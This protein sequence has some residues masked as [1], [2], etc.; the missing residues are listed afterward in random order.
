MTEKEEDG[1]DPNK[2]PLHL[3]HQK[4]KNELK[5]VSEDVIERYFEHIKQEFENKMKE[6]AINDA[7][8][9]KKNKN[10][11]FTQ[12]GSTKTRTKQTQSSSFQAVSRDNIDERAR[13]TRKGYSGNEYNVTDSVISKKPVCLVRI[14]QHLQERRYR[15]EKGGCSK[16]NTS[17]C[18]HSNE[19]VKGQIESLK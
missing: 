6:E 10:F 12:Y 2:V 13:N 1:L 19:R 18:R 7:A 11:N 14:A 9:L 4:L 15:E 3:I 8:Q 17:H 16:G 5:G